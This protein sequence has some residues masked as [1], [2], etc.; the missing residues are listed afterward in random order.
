MLSVVCMWHYKIINYDTMISFYKESPMQSVGEENNDFYKRL[1]DEC[2]PNDTIREGI[3][4]FHTS[5]LS[6][7]EKDTFDRIMKKEN[8]TLLQFDENGWLTVRSESLN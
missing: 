6:T 4:T 8:H 3:G 2:Q 1:K 7:D 5:K